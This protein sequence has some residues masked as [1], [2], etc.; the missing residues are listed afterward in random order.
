MH[1]HTPVVC[2]HCHLI[3]DKTFQHQIMVCLPCSLEPACSA[4][5]DI[6]RSVYE[7]FPKMGFGVYEVWVLQSS[8]RSASVIQS[9]FYMADSSAEPNPLIF[10]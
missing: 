4:L 10:T 9:A 3:K 8:S 6:T 5:D 1:T 2:C 7:A